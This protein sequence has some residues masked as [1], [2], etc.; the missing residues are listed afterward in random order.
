VAK[1]DVLDIEAT[2]VRSVTVDGARAQV[3]C[4]PKLN[5]KSDGP[6][7]V[8]VGGGCGGTL[9]LPSAQ[10]CVD[11]RKFSFRLH[12]PR[13]ARIVLVEAFVNGHR[14]LRLRGGDIRRITLARLPRGRFTVRIVATQNTGSKL[15]ST[16]R[17]R[18][19]LKS[20]PTTRAHHHRR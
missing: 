4:S 19:C 17:Y 20:R 3:G 2:N 5:V 18:G 1:E 11:R 15:I 13:G 6:L 8:V 16:R 14:R 12:R 10:R 7:D 9:K